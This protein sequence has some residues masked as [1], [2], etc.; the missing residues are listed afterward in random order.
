MS[1]QPFANACIHK[2]L[3]TTKESLLASVAATYRTAMDNDSTP[4]SVYDNV[5][6]QAVAVQ[7]LKADEPEQCTHPHY[8]TRARIGKRE[9]ARLACFP[10]R[11]IYELAPSQSAG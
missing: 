1:I 7:R 3:P 4:F 10:A 8:Q 6:R 9:V 11:T 2:H 5:P